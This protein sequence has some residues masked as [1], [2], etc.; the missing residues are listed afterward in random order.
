MKTPTDMP[1]WN[2]TINI[3]LQIRRNHKYNVILF[4][5][6]MHR[7]E[8]YTLASSKSWCRDLRINIW[9][10]PRLGRWLDCADWNTHARGSHCFH[11]FGLFLSFQGKRPDNPVATQYVQAEGSHSCHYRPSSS[12]PRS[13]KG[14]QTLH[15]LLCSPVVSDTSICTLQTSL[16]NHGD[17]S[18]HPRWT[19]RSSKWYS[20]L[21]IMS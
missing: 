10:G 6:G 8:Q 4:H 15:H 7:V 12:I 11:L 9:R 5:S 17:T 1:Q 16:A 14:E 21:C 18:R 20:R 13:Y 2:K 19:T 3:K